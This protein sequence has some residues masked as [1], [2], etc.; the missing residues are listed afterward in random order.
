MPFSH[1][2]RSRTRNPISIIIILPR[3]YRE[4]P[5]FMYIVLQHQSSMSV[6][7][8]KYVRHW[9]AI[10]CGVLQHAFCH[11]PRSSCQLARWSAHTVRA[12]ALSDTSRKLGECE[13]KSASI[14]M[15]QYFF[16]SVC[17]YTQ[18]RTLRA[19]EMMIEKFHTLNSIAAAE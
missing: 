12:R 17:K 6:I 9:V 4:S 3:T 11:I 16:Q 2:L 1:P 13:T 8:Y 10:M 15:L 7:N 19:G 18:Q 14:L 5:E